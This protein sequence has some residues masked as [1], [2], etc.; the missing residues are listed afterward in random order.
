MT[1][2]LQFFDSLGAYKLHLFKQTRVLVVSL[3]IYGPMY[4]KLFTRPL[5]VAS[6]LFAISQGA[7]SAETFLS[8]FLNSRPVQ[9][10]D[11]QLDNS[12]IGE[13]S[14]DGTLIFAMDAGEHILELSE[15][16]TVVLRYSYLTTQRENAEIS[17]MFSD[18]A[19]PPEVSIEKYFP[20]AEK[21]GAPGIIQGAVSSRD[22]SPIRGA[23]VSLVNTQY[24]V[25]TSESGG[26]LLEVPRGTY[27]LEVSHPEYRTST[28]EDVRVVANVGLAVNINLAAPQPA[29]RLELAAP[30]LAPI[31]EVLILGR[32]DPTDTTIS[33]ERMSTAIV[34]A[35]DA[36]QLA[37]FGDSSA[38]G[39]LKRVAGVDVNDGKYAVVRGLDG[40]Y[41]SSTLNG[42]LMPT[43][44]PL[45]RDVQLD[46]FP[47]N[48]LGSI[49]IQKSYTADMPGDTT[50][51]SI[52]MAT[53]NAP[54]ER[55][56][57]ISLAAGYN[58]H[59]TGDDIVSY[60]GSDSDWF[61]YDDGLRDVPVEVDQV[62]LG[63]AGSQFYSVN[64]CNN[65]SS[66]NISYEE[67]ARLA[68]QFP[69]IYDVTTEQAKPDF[70]LG[71]AYGNRSELSFG[72]LGY[73]G[74]VSFKN[75]TEARLDAVVNSVT[76]STT[77][78]RST[79]SAELGAYLVF[80]LEDNHGSEWLSKTIF[81]RQADDVTR[82]ESGVNTN[83]DTHFETA[84]LHWTERQYIAQQFSATHAFFDTHAFDWRVGVS[85]TSV[86]EPDRRRWMYLEGTFV[87]TL[88]ERRYSELTEDGLDFG[89]DYSLPIDFSANISTDLKLGY[90]F[91][92]RDREWDLAR[93]SFRQGRG[94]NPDDV[95][96]GPEIL[97][98]HESLENQ[99]YQLR[100][101]TAGG[102]S[103]LAEIETSAYYLQSE[104]KFADSF[105]L[106]AGAR[107]EDN[108]Q[109]IEYPYSTSAD[110]SP[111]IL[112]ESD[113]LPVFGFGYNSNDVWQFRISASQTVSRPGIIERSR[114][115]MY[116]PDT[117]DQ[118]F[119]NPDLV[120]SSI[121]NIDLRL[122]YYWDDGGS[123]S[124]AVFGKQID[125]PIE[126]TIP[127]GSG[128]AVRNS[129]TFRNNLSAD[130][131]G[132]ELDGY[133][134]IMENANWSMFV[135]GN[136]SFIES[137][138]ELNATSLRL[139]GDDSMGRELQGQSP[140]LANIQFGLDH[141]PT[142]QQATLLINYFDDKIYKVGR[143]TL[144]G[145][146]IELG[147]ASVDFTYEKEFDNLSKIN[148]KLENILNEAIEYSQNDV[149]IESYKKGTELSVKYTYSF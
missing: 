46:L 118:I 140:F 68:Q 100:K 64:T 96:A 4:M 111:S 57:Q 119:G 114:S 29:N 27:T 7:W 16:D 47:A 149:I 94:G 128:S 18:M 9:G 148:V 70:G 130:V 127:E 117:D 91:N 40:R 55:V 63:E 81:L 85:Q 146:E 12:A 141:S 69:L 59:L 30:S 1:L 62:F 13:T 98:S 88:L 138:V 51:G 120:S 99:Y 82:L 36:E 103:F 10:L 38:A 142:G 93:Y 139:E 89:F 42:D 126:R 109:I 87:P 52:G 105:T 44:D 5:F 143:G 35:I 133:K 106:V 22:G 67:T 136:L 124:L 24:Q 86:N 77:Y 74:S 121:D 72:S 45:R 92:N 147:R 19:E 60:E 49:Q 41:I 56:H 26:Y 2:L 15:N 54:D 108:E 102:D 39:A 65:S 84:I 37:R 73:Y 21:S 137:E 31:E 28:E 135:S 3:R 104:T 66:C 83:E 25:I 80:G 101:S 32:F 132:I 20:G 97:L 129:Y 145:N 95:T 23:T 75:E 33:I 71:Y 90:L 122:E 43:T 34:D 61:T 134:V 17:V 50:G 110:T 79:K 115:T 116:D 131:G 112:D 113:T 53:R 14:S 6:I 8:V 125:N 11:V 107:V 48:I 58:F 144:L 123:I 78:D 76:E